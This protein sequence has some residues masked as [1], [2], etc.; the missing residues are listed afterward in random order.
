MP[1]SSLETLKDAI[2]RNAG[3]VLSL[4]STG[5]LRHFKSRFLGVCGSDA[6]W[7]Q[8]VSS[9]HSLVE[10]LPDGGRP[11]GVSFINGTVK[12][13]FVTHVRRLDAAHQVG[14]TTVAAVLMAMPTAVTLTQRRRDYRVEVPPDSGITVKVWRIAGRAYLYD[15]PMPSQQVKCELRDLSL[16]GIGVTF[17]GVHGQPPNVSEGDRL[18][19]EVSNRET[20]VFLEG[21]MRRP[22]AP[23][24][25]D[26]SVIRTGIVF[27]QSD[28][29]IEGRQAQ[30]VLTRFIGQLQ[31]DEV[32]RIRISA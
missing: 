19:V 23:L 1:P 31:R 32:R 22:T 17:S 9:D 14:A 5:A 27:T 6:F 7:A 30:A 16:G 18:R 13:T 21:R 2:A 12:A 24:D 26:P 8:W 25:P 28:Q 15:L 20:S 29:D 10:G 3:A 11:A 4:P